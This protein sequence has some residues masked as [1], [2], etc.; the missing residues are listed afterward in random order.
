MSISG[1]HEI[2]FD[3]YELRGFEVSS[4]LLAKIARPETVVMIGSLLLEKIRAVLHQNDGEVVVEAE[5]FAGK[6]MTFQYSPNDIPFVESA[7]DIDGAPL[8][9]AY[10]T[11]PQ[12]T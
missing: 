9:G 7:I 1:E 10:G 11:P 5:V 2:C 8:L 4:A 12:N 6:D 3:L